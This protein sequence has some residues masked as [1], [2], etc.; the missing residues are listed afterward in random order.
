[1]ASLGKAQLDQSVQN[2]FDDTDSIPVDFG[3]GQDIAQSLSAAA[4]SSPDGNQERV[5]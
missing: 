5:T 4:G 2:P 3:G 1:M